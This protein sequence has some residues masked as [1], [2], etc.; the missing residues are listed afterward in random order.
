MNLLHWLKSLHR[1]EPVTAAEIRNKLNALRQEHAVTV[2]QRDLL[3]LDAVNSEV[4]AA[5]WT[6]LEDTAQQLA[7]RIDVLAAA[8]PQAE[9][10]EA[11]AAREAEAVARAKRMQDYQRQTSGAQAWLDD[12][13]R[14]L[15][16]GEELTK[17]QTL[18]DALRNDARWLSQWSR[19]IAVRRPFDPLEAIHDALALRVARIERAKWIH[20]GHPITLGSASKQEAIA[21]AAARIEALERTHP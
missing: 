15:P 4:A 18:R 21:T 2:R 17:A 16:S 10:K 19:D 3:A 12:V 6:H 14:R 8:L 13:L 7:Q 20:G 11:Q 9:A 5:R 1:S